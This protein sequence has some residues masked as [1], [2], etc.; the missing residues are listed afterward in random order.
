M[1]H[2]VYRTKLLW[3]QIDSN[4]H[5]RHSAYADLACQARVEVLEQMG[6]SSIK[7]EELA[8]GPILFEEQTVYK[9]EVPPNTI[10]SVSCL[11]Q[12]CRAD[13]AR[14]SFRQEIFRADGV[15]AA[16]VTTV[17]AWMDLNKRKI[18]IPP[19]FFAEQLLTLMP[20]TADCNVYEK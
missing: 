2:I 18:T 5:L 6:I 7:M 3:S 14:W 12:S 11:L 4:N 10:V 17:G 15:L 19:S 20:R 9:R 16:V 1:E 8:I 13:A